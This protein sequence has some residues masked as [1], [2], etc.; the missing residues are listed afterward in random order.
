MQGT[1]YYANGT[2][3][4]FSI[5]KKYGRYFGAT[6]YSY[7]YPATPALVVTKI[8]ISATCSVGLSVESTIWI[9]S[10]RT[11]ECSLPSGFI[12]VGSEFKSMLSFVAE[13]VG[14]I[15]QVEF[16]DSAGN[17]I[18]CGNDWMSPLAANPISKLRVRITPPN[19][20]SETLF[21]KLLGIVILKRTKS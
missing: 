2:N 6:E 18:A 21:T 13:E 5:T 20:T 15:H 1:I 11:I 14:E 8:S 9:N 19:S 7:I 10:Q 12:T 4:P 16:V 3:Q 17:T